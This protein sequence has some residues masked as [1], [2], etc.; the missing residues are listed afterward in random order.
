LYA[1]GECTNDEGGYFIVKGIERT[2]IAQ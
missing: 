2:I 1:L